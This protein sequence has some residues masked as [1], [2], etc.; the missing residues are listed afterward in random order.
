MRLLA[1]VVKNPDQVDLVREELTRL[2]VQEVTTLE[3]KPGPEDAPPGTAVTVGLKRLLTGLGGQSTSLLQTYLFGSI[4][5]I[6]PTDVWVTVGLTVVVIVVCVGLAPQL[7]AVAQDPEFARVA[8]LRVGAYNLA[9]AVLA[10]SGDSSENSVA[11]LIRALD[12][13]SAEDALRASSAEGL[14]ALLEE[15]APP[16]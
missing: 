12:D 6:S 14:G 9:V 3:S 4:T 13:A 11:A 16:P 10:G 2:G 1:V 5:T 15:S 7:Y 8:G